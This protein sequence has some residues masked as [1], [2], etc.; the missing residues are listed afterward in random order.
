MDVKPSI[1]ALSC[2]TITPSSILSI[3]EMFF[4]SE[5]KILMT[6]SMTTNIF[7]TLSMVF[8]ALP[9][10]S[11]TFSSL[12]KSMLRVK[13]THCDPKLE[14]SPDTAL[15][16]SPITEIPLVSGII[17]GSVKSTSSMSRSSILGTTYSGS[18]TN[19]NLR[20]IGTS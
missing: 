4:K 13:S 1:M 3:I 18:F 15:F 7:T 20:P 17:T 10:T 16:S 9:T 12:F 8:N 2:L 11:T 14:A 19:L 6:L 5:L